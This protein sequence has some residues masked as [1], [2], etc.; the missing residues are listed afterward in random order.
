[1]A[2]RWWIASCLALLAGG[3]A[4]A[5]EVPAPAGA[6][7]GAQLETIVVTGEQPGPGLWQVRKDGHVMWVL[8]TLAPLPRDMRWRAGEVGERIAQSK[9]ML[10]APSLMIK[11][12][13]G[14]FGRIALAPWLVGVRNNPDHRRLKDVL[15]PDLYARWQPLKQRY[16]GRGNKVEKWRPLF[17]AMELYRAAVRANGMTVGSASVTDQ[18]DHFAKQ[19]KLE[20]TPVRIE[21]PVESPRA[22]IKEFK[23]SQLD[24]IDCFARTIERLETDLGTMKQRAN[25]WA[26]GDLAAL[27]ALPYV[28]QSDACFEAMQHTRVLQAAGD[29]EARLRQRWLDAAGKALDAHATS[30]ALLPMGEVVGKDGYLEALRARGYEIVAPDAD[31]AASDAA[32]AAAPSP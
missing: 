10:A 5:Q 18:V 12:D 15:P 19:A 14:W 17:A 32:A 24:D 23:R 4:P 8:G 6:D 27:R 29:I 22:A 26:S 30:F 9:A 16:L 7:A 1:M 28:D 2:G 31:E 11:S 3:L 21:V 20:P 13:V 25:A